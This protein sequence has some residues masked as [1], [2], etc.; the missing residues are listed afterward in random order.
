[1]IKYNKHDITSL[2]C[3]YQLVGGGPGTARCHAVQAC[4]VRSHV[5]DVPSSLHSPCCTRKQRFS[6]LHS[7]RT[8]KQ[9]FSSLHSPCCTRKQ[10]FSS[11][12]TPRT[13]K[14]QLLLQ[15][16]GS[17]TQSI[18]NN[19]SL[20]IYDNNY[21]KLKFFTY[22]LFSLQSFSCPPVPLLHGWH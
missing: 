5:D 3:T 10:R 15:L 19:V 13:R 12:H 21:T 4:C 7:P 16:N 22:Q 11:L 17:S 20:Q 2:H 9:R 8:R 6:S 1:M 18:L 14:S